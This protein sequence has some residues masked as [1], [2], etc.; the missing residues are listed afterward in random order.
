MPTA[1]TRASINTMSVDMLVKEED[2]LGD[3]KAW[4]ELQNRVRALR[5]QLLDFL[6][7]LDAFAPILDPHKQISQ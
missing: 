5:A 7:A 4:R 1:T 2:K 3:C 6:R